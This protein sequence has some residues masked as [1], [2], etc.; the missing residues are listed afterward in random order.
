MEL[1]PI[2][3]WLYD[4]LI[5][6]G[7]GLLAADIVSLFGVAVIV[8]GMLSVMALFLVWWERKIGG[9]IQQRFGPMRTGWHGWYQ[10][11]MDAIKLLQKEDVRIVQ[12]RLGQPQALPEAVRQLRDA[13]ADA[14]S[15]TAAIHDPI[16]RR[17]QGRAAQSVEGA[18]EV[19]GGGDAHLGPP[20]G[21]RRAAGRGR[22]TLPPAG[23]IVPPV[24]D[25][26]EGSHGACGKRNLG[27]SFVAPRR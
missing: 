23:P 10:T 3:D 27:R 25:G 18:V 16:P 17:L 15:Q 12:E 4:Q 13:L 26:R 1:A 14:L 9:H 20:R 5:N 22:L 21:P 24:G 7:L 6:L 11:I 8:F 2:F 19:Q